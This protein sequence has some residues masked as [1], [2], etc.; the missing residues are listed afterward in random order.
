[1]YFVSVTTKRRFVSFDFKTK[2]KVRRN[3]GDMK[4]MANKNSMSVI[5]VL[6]FSHFVYY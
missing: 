6:F 2:K 4:K 5:T 3:D 1:M